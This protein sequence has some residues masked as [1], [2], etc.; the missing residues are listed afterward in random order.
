MPELSDDGAEI[1]YRNDC[2]ELYFKSW[3]YLVKKIIYIDN[4]RI[5][6][7]CPWECSRLINEFNKELEIEPVLNLM[8]DRSLWASF[9]NDFNF[10][11]V[12]F[13]LKFYGKRIVIMIF[14]K[15]IVLD[16]EIWV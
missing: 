14:L 10:S 8:G 16:Q 11:E 13:Q 3:I 4:L 9:I 1:I 2:V 6:R 7:E 5:L 15:S 12:F